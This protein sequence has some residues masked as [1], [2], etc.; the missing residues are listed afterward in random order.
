MFLY[1]ELSIFINTFITKKVFFYSLLLLG[2]FARTLTVFLLVFRLSLPELLVSFV[3]NSK[4]FVISTCKK[5]SGN[6][7]PPFEVRRSEL[8]LSWRVC[9][10]QAAICKN[11]ARRVWAIRF[12]NCNGPMDRLSKYALSVWPVFT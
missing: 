8:M 5:A 1:W 11:C 9:N 12:L 3:K 4:S 10:R 7:G 6:W 2:E